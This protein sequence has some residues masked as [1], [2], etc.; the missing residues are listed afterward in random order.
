MAFTTI[1]DPEL[2]F[3]TKIYTGNGTSSTAITLDGDQNMQ[4]NLVWTKCRSHT[5]DHGVQDS[6]RGVS[7][8]FHTNSS[9]V[10]ASDGWLT[11]LDSDGFTLSNS[12]EVNQNTRTFIAYCWKE[13]ATAGFD[14]VPWTGNQSAR[15]ISH[16][17]S[18]VPDF[19]VTKGRTYPSDWSV[20]HEAFDYTNDD[21]IYLSSTGGK[22]TSS[23]MFNGTAPTSSVFS[24]GTGNNVNKSSETYIAYLWKG[25]TGYSK[26]GTYRSSGTSDDAQFVYLG[27]KPAFVIHKR[28]DSSGDW[29]SW[30]N[31][32]NP[33]N[34]M[35]HSIF[36]NTDATEY[37][38]NNVRVHFVSNGIQFR[39]ADTTNNN[40]SGG[41]FIYMAWAESPF[42]N[43]EGVPNNAR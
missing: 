36:P 40:P 38:T 29:R 35:D 17:L 14:I 25:K 8:V 22:S 42:V 15:T 41:T 21:F 26:F 31:K 2:Y 18:A 19:L 37:D 4:P 30:N 34:P 43:S 1:D 11:S 27:F 28:I 33:Y 39:Q 13:S 9:S 5:V 10:A 6:V 24:I 16:S 20:G 7:E 3:Q 32:S 23:L 12:N